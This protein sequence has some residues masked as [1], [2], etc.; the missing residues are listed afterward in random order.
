MAAF[1]LVVLCHAWVIS[2][3][4][5]VLQVRRPK[6]SLDEADVTDRSHVLIDEGVHVVPDTSCKTERLTKLPTRPETTTNPKA[7]P[8]GG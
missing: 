7:I 8:G 2:S 4:L 1:G 6:L 5:R 3:R